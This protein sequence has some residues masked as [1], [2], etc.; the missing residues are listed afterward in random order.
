MILVSPV[1]SDATPPPPAAVMVAI[2][3]ATRVEMARTRRMM[4]AS[5]A[6]AHTVA[7]S[8]P[9][10]RGVFMVYANRGLGSTCINDD[11]CLASL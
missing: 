9:M 7:V 1:H 5:N 2:V 11:T 8:R 6:A 10:K 4:R 3:Y